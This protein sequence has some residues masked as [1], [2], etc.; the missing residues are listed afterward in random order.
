MKTGKPLPGAKLILS[1]GKTVFA[2]GETGKD[3]V[4]KAV[5]KELREA[6][7]LRVFAKSDVG[8]AS[9]MIDLSGIGVATGLQ[10]LGLIYTDRPAYRAGQVV[11]IRGVIR[12]AINDEYVLD[13]TRKYQLEVFD[14]RNRN[15]WNEKLT[16]TEFGGVRSLFTLP[17]TSP[18][19]SYRIVI[20][21]VEQT[22]GGFNGSFLVQDYSL[23][24]IRLSIEAD[25][26][27]VYRG[28]ELT[29]KIVA[30]YYYGA[31]LAG[32]EIRYKLSDGPV[33]VARTD[34]RG[35]IA[36]KF[37]TRELREAQIATLSVT[38]TD[39]NLTIGENFIV[40][41]QGFSLN[42]TT[43]RPVY[44]SGESWEASV[45][46]KDAEGKP[47]KQK[48]TLTLLKQNVVNGRVGETEVSK[49]DVETDAKTGVVKKTFQLDK[50]G[51]Y[52]LRAEG[53][54]RF[55]NAVSGQ[56]SVGVSGDEDRVRLR[57]LADQLTWEVG[58]TAKARIHWRKNRRWRW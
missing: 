31:A 55:E 18:S 14:P 56:G 45:T 27:I 28:E 51:N 23:E 48:L 37:P 15:V 40:A 20:R 35:E 5:H 38:L 10:D 6:P 24:P 33:T 47:L 25:K 39:R 42:V 21:D 13:K 4:Y 52:I 46:A 36:Y 30:K 11:H 2:E 54:D 32:K 29:G 19:G 49:H 9:N 44:I 7:S 34:A 53:I 1:D 41:S 12:R 17:A 26:R 50:G 3:G 16:P 43:P 57:I 22:S 58:Q 8:S